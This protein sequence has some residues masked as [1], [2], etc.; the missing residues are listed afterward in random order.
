MKPN[1]LI[2]R[3]RLECARR[4]HGKIVRGQCQLCGQAISM[5]KNRLRGGQRE[6]IEEL[7]RFLN[8]GGGELTEAEEEA[9]QQIRKKE[10]ER[11]EA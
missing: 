11:T 9:M 8:E 2:Q 6:R 7:F 3:K 5:E 1:Q 4:G 10:D